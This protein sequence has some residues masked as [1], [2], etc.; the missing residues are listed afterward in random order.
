M[1]LSAQ[2]IVRS[3]VE[4]A[5]RLNIQTIAEFVSSASIYEECKELGIDYIQ[6][7]YLSEPKDSV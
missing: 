7:Y 6:G 4:F 1:D 2:D 3:I 5:N